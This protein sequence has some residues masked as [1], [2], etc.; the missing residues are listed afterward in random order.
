MALI[1]SRGIQVNSKN[2]LNEQIPRQQKGLPKEAE[3][4][5]FVK[6]LRKVQAAGFLQWFQYYQ[7]EPDKIADIQT[8]F[9]SKNS[10]F[11]QINLIH[12]SKQVGLVLEDILS[13]FQPFL[14]LYLYGMYVMETDLFKKVRI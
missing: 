4:E 14:F 12:G 10:K 3:E 8:V 6:L 2:F 5:L 13:L 7:S 9:T 11:T 1:N